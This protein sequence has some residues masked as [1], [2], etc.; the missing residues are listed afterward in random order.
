MPGDPSAAD[1]LRRAAA[2]WRESWQRRRL[3]G[4]A[5]R[6]AEGVAA[7]R[8]RRRRRGARA[9]DARA[10]RAHRRVA[11]RPLRGRR[12]RCS[13][14]A[15][16]TEAR[17]VAESLRE[18]DDFPHD[19]ADALAI[20]AAHDVVDY[21]QALDSV[22]TSFETREDFLEEAAVADTALVLDLAR[23]R[24]SPS[25]CRRRRSSLP[26]QSASPCSI[27]GGTRS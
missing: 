15:R 3:L 24:G 27:A 22:V 12:S 7:R 23:R 6:R 10:R 5:D 17:H 14:S 26:C 20:I 1:W 16:W 25:R 8:R 21:A 4:A 11:D 19:V 2:R 9:L 18:R 13:R